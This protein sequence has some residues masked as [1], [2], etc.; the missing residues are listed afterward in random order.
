MGQM[1]KYFYKWLNEI[2]AQGRALI[3]QIDNYKIGTLEDEIYLDDLQIT[4]ED[5]YLVSGNQQRRIFNNYHAI[6]Y[7][8]AY[9]EYCLE[10]G[11]AVIYFST[12]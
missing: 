11:D 1:Q 4:A 6:S 12:L 7:S 10:Y 5:I 2:Y 3:I 8:R 9:D